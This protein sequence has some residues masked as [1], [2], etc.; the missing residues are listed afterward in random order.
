MQ[1]LQDDAAAL[2]Q[3]RCGS[4]LDR[5]HAS[6][7]DWKESA[8]PL[9]DALHL[10]GKRC[11]HCGTE[12]ADEARLIRWYQTDR[13]KCSSCGAF[14]TSLTG[15]IL[16]GSTLD[17]RELYLLQVLLELDVD[18]VRIASVLNVNRETVKR[19]KKRLYPERTSA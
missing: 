5:L 7:L 10:D 12:I 9:I 19:W 1:Q 17:P 16:H 15:T 6:S 14:Y 8:W 3:Y 13:I 2:P 4:A 18:A 11:P